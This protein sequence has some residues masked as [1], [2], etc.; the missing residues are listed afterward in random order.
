MDNLYKA[1]EVQVDLSTKVGAKKKQTKMVKPGV[2]P[3]TNLTPKDIKTMSPESFINELE[4]TIDRFKNYVPNP[5]QIAA[6]FSVD[7]ADLDEYIMSHKEVQKSWNMY[8]QLWISDFFEYCTEN[9]VTDK[10]YAIK[11]ANELF[12]IADTSK[13]VPDIRFTLG[14]DFF[15]N[16]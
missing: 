1:S 11:I 4:V 10:H 13:R 5:Y 8:T 7:Y 15:A 14:K 6:A 9:K 3:L 12:K 16:E 2:K